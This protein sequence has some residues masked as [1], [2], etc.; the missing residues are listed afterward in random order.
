MTGQHGAPF[1]PDDRTRFYQDWQR[2]FG[3]MPLVRDRLN[4]NRR[5]GDELEQPPKVPQDSSPAA[6]ISLIEGY[7]PLSSRR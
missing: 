5:Q 1:L 3:R 4:E 6:A 7:L 2:H